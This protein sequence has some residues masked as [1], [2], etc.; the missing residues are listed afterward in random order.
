VFTFDQVLA[1]IGG[2]AGIVWAI[3]SGL[4][5]GYQSFRYESHL[6]RSMYTEDKKD[7]CDEEES[8]DE[9]E[10]KETIRNRKPYNYWLSEFLKARLSYYLCCC[11]KSRPWYTNS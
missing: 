3:I 1:Y 6:M 2:Y 10:I 9:E 7:R 4:V 11:F 5:G 8:D